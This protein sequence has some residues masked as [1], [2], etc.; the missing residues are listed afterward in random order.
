MSLWVDFRSK[1]IKQN[2]KANWFLK[3]LTESLAHEDTAPTFASPICQC[4]IDYNVLGNRGHVNFITSKDTR[5]NPW[6]VCRQQA[7]LSH[8]YFLSLLKVGVS[9][10]NMPQLEGHVICI[11]LWKLSFQKEWEGCCFIFCLQKAHRRQL[12]VADAVSLLH[13]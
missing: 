4:C 3:N 6:H 10:K 2:K 11:T 5:W 7:R 9:L 1:K 12:S 8:R 13:G